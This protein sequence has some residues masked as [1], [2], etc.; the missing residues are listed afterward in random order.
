MLY[1]VLC[2]IGRKIGTGIPNYKNVYDFLGN[3]FPR[4]QVKYIIV[5]YTIL[6]RV[7]VL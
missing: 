4:K 3:I 2:V 6:C 5:M 7:N 1:T